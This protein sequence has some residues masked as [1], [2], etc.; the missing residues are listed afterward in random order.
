[1]LMPQLL[2]PAKM[3]DAAPAIE[4]ATADEGGDNESPLLKMSPD[5]QRVATECQTKW[6]M[7]EDEVLT[8]KIHA[9]DDRPAL[10]ATPTMASTKPR[11]GAADALDLLQ[12]HLS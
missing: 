11:L 5:Q 4:D 8:W 12:A 6:G 3:G 1:M 2:G 10:G 7:G 9:D